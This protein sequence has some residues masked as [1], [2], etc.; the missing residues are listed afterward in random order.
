MLHGNILRNSQDRG[1]GK[2]LNYFNLNTA[3][4]L[5]LCCKYVANILQ[6]IF[7][8]QTLLSIIFVVQNYL[9]LPIYVTF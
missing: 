6:K 1:E 7:W 4:M 2:Y 9:F 5:Q 3:S 8:T